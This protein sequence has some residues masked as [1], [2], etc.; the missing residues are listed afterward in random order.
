[1][2]GVAVSYVELN[3]RAAGSLWDGAAGGSDV[4]LT[5]IWGMLCR[6]MIKQ[7]SRGCTQH[8]QLRA[9]KVTTCL[10]D[11]SHENKAKSRQN[12]GRK[13]LGHM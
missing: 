12:N 11:M 8:S 9:T 13:K 7:R 4:S 5:V 2:L 10:F 1:M 6:E 3:A